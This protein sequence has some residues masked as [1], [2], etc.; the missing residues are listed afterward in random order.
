MKLRTTLILL[1]A[2]GAL[3]ALIGIFESRQPGTRE[4][5]ALE[6]RPFASKT[7]GADEIEIERKGDTLRLLLRNGTWRIGQ[8]FDDAA[9]PD[10][11]KQMLEAIPA[12]EWVETIK[13][14][15]LRRE[16]IKRT[17]LG[18]ASLKVTLRS[19]GAPLMQFALGASAALEGCVY[20]SLPQHKDEFHIARTTLPTLLG[21]TGDEWRDPRLARLK[22][23][24]VQQFSINAGT[25][26]MEFSRTPGKGW[27]IVKPIQT[28]ASDERVNAIISALINLKVKPAKIALPA[29]TAGPDMPV[30][31]VF[32][33][34]PGIAQPLELTLHPNADPSAEVQTQAS[35]RE[36]V[37]LASAKVGDFWK[38]QPNHLRDQNLVAVPKDQVT[39]LRIR[40]LANAEVVLDKQ[41]ET[42]MLKRFGQVEPANQDRVTKLF[43][44]LNAAQVREFLSDS[45]TPT[46]LETWG[47]H[48]PLLSIEWQ[49][50][51][52]ASVL[53]FG[54]GAAGV[55]T[56]H[57]VDEPFVYRV[58]TSLLNSI[59]PDSLRW[60]GT[61]II[62]ASIFAAR[63]IVLTEGDRPAVSLFHNP[64]DATWTASIA[65]RDVTSQ[66][67]KSLAN[68]LLQK[69]VDFQAIDWSSDRSGAI[70]ALRNPSLTIQLL[71][72][73]PGSPAS[74]A[75]PVT[76]S[77][78]PLQPGMDTALYHG[79]KN[80]EPDTFLIPRELYHELVKTVV[81]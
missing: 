25:G 76:L 19:K 63:R 9:D 42:W 44:A 62:S 29:P 24:D 43:D 5:S 77:F 15:D 73:T 11:V 41:G 52:K 4:K 70:M 56:A 40:S 51:G 74:E 26:G 81:K 30:L 39:S 10:L 78:A 46:N 2:T 79:R 13:R 31:N 71:L 18:D 27:Q 12:V 36:G 20:A 50:G 72:S 34:G 23:D 35:N 8:P 66:L 28:R 1:F 54:Q 80:E 16:D 33:T 61:R 58:N 53:Q 75:R 57:V 7:A 38:L 65:G 49:A 68:Q 55:L 22:I 37:F 47:L 21:R 60:R 64:D 59:P 67:D 6:V 17:G 14:D 3:L 32:F 69:L 48:Q 45:A